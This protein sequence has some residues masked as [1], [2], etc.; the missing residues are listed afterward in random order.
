MRD[1]D[2]LLTSLVNIDRNSL[3]AILTS[4]AE[5]AQRS[6]KAARERTAS[7]RAKR[8]Q[9][10]EQLA[11]VDRVLCFFQRGEIAPEMSASDIKLCRSVE[12]RLHGRRNA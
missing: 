1:L 2:P 10:L 5:A 3:I 4:E 7:Q 6:V 11:R 12:R 9:A 8:R